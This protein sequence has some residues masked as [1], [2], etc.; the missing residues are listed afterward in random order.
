MKRLVSGLLVL[1]M[2][3]S[4]LT[5]C[6]GKD[7]DTSAEGGKLVVGI[8]QRSSIADY[9]NNAFTKY[10]EENTGVK[11]KFTYFSSTA[12]EY[13]QQLALT[14][15]SGDDL[16]DVLLG[17][18][19]LGVRL[20]TAYGEDGYFIDLTDLIDK[21]ADSY[22]A[23][24]E[25]LSDKEKEMVE[26]KCK[27]MDSDA[28]YAMP[29]VDEVLIDNIQSLTFINQTWL[30][31]V[32][33]KAPT[34]TDELYAVLQAF[35]TQ[36]P[37]GNGKQDEIPMLGKT[38]IINY[39]MNAFTYFE[40]RHPYNVENGT[41]YAPF[42]TDEYRQGLQFLNKLLK[43]GLYSDLSFSVTASSE[44][45]NMYTPSSGVA[46]VGIVM[47]H[48]LTYMDTLN[49][50]MDQYVA[51]GSLGDATGKGGYYVVSDDT[52]YA[53]A[54]ITSYCDNPELAMKFI[55]FFYEDGTVT[56]AR[57]GEKGVDWEEGEVG[58]DTYG[59]EVTTYVKNSQAF[60]EGSQ[61]WGFVPCGIL[62]AKAYNSIAS[63]DNASGARV[64]KILRG[65]VELMNT[66][67]IK[68]DTV[69]NLGYTVEEDDVNEKY[70]STITDYVTEQRDLFILGT[71]DINN[72]ADWNA[73]L[74]EFDG[75][76]LDEIIKVKQSAYDRSV[77]K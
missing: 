23:K 67:P 12:S 14:A 45:K 7:N 1:M 33:M 31:A 64:S 24:Y 11:I 20:M 74:S 38:A 36:D 16:P 58:T 69:R 76:S 47:G 50:V 75:L 48:P 46:K 4:L 2:F 15:S 72:D 10:L 30:D 63:D 3:C 19:D 26:L 57:H 6:G 17:F 22:K 44:L 59:N 37:N 53:S 68:E 21:Y 66:C 73:Y 28:I 35:K 5:G 55:D 62:D 49:E 42:T 25:T 71:K 32:G 70:S 9:D 29:R 60:T 52:V 40:Q 34:T 61:T 51:L 13:K 56:R 41:V 77:E 8:P 43:E 65:S 18:K 39:V 54:F 27:S